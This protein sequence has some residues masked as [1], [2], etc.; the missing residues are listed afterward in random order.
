MPVKSPEAYELIVIGGGPGGYVAAIRAAQLGLSVALVDR[1]ETLGG[2]C[3]NIGCIP[4][5]ALL[6]SSELYERAAKGLTGHGIHLE[7]V[8][9]DLPAMMERKQAVVTRLVTGVEALVKAQGITRIHGSARLTGPGAVEVALASGGLSML[10][11]KGVVLATG[12]EPVALPALPADG[13]S[14]VT[15]TEALSLT[16]V[17]RS[18]VVV[19]GGAVGL[20]LGSVW[21]RLGSA[22]TV[23]ELMPQILPGWDEEVSRLLARSL[24]RQGLQILTGSKVTEARVRDGAVRLVVAGP[25]GKPRE[26]EAEKVLVAVGRRPLTEGIGLAS[27]GIVPDPRTGRVPVNGRLEAAPGVYA[28]GD[29]APGP[30]LAHKAEDEGMAVAE[31]AAGK[32]GHVSY[33]SIPLVVY[34]EPEAASVGKTERELTEAGVA[35]RKGTFPFRANGRALALESTEGMVKILADAATDRLLGAQIVGPRASDLVAE[36][37]AVLE[38]GGSAEDIA[39]T[40]HAH[41]TLSEVVREAALDVEGRAIHAPPRGK[42]G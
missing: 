37:V 38:F 23:I 2:T 32:A 24:G 10:S 21:A 35:Y 4:S 41:P 34:T 27:V 1:R 26:L 30:A 19:G 33:G 29:I 39:R 40:V 15:S 20:E 36:L 11:G 5:K 42:V 17:P 22:V 18:L 28:I 16:A 13:T 12:G 31:W 25:D 7:G 9:L 14:I 3:L 6:D 8:R